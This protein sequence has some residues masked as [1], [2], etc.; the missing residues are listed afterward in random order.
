MCCYIWMMNC[1][2]HGLWCIYKYSWSCGVTVST[3]DSESQDPSSNL[4]KTFCITFRHYNVTVFHFDRSVFIGVSDREKERGNQRQLKETQRITEDLQNYNDWL[5]IAG[6]Y[7]VCSVVYFALNSS[8]LLNLYQVFWPSICSCCTSLQLLYVASWFVAA[9]YVH[10][11]ISLSLVISV[12]GLCL[13]GSTPGFMY[14]WF[15]L[16]AEMD[17]PS[18]TGSIIDRRESFSFAHTR[19]ASLEN[20]IVSMSITIYL[21]LPCWHSV[22]WGTQWFKMPRRSYFPFCRTQLVP[23]D[24]SRLVF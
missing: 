9:L 17:A 24:W 3:W 6:W 12:I 10:S 8:E 16:A 1:C 15:V 14:V 4:G 23:V 13:I 2:M 5:R 7:I 19:Q 21:Y 22:L 20:S 18:D 11:I